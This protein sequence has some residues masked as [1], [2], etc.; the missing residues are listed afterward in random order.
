[1]LFVRRA[2]LERLVAWAAR[3]RLAGQERR[4]RSILMDTEHLLSTQNIRH[5]HLYS[6]T[7]FFFITLSSFAPKRYYIVR[8]AAAKYSLRK[9]GWRPS[10]RL[11]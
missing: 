11:T 4:Y 6:L 8:G 3:K 10:L 1:M 9:A 2:E 7:D 5:L